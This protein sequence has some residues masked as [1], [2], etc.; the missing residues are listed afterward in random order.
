MHSNGAVRHCVYN[1]SVKPVLH[2]LHSRVLAEE[3]DDV[4]LTKAIKS[5]SSC[6]PWWEVLRSY[7]WSALGHSQFCWSQIQSII[8]FCRPCPCHSGE[9]ENRDGVSSCRPHRTYRREHRAFCI[10]IRSKEAKEI[11][12]KL[13]QRKQ[14][15]P[16]HCTHCVTSARI[17]REIH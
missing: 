13:F 15:S 2:I 14:G 17:V 5:D 7:H 8:H 4:E 11:I 10:F 9:N 1:S 6:I 12:G 16:F 3:E